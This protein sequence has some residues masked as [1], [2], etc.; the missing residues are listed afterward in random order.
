MKQ[1][2]KL[3]ALSILSISMVS[4]VSTLIIGVIPQLANEFP[5]LPLVWSE[6]LVT[7]ANLSALLTLLLNPRLSAYFGA[8]K[9]VIS[10]LLI[11]MITGALPFILH[12]FTLLMLSRILLGLG[13]GLFSPHALSLIARVYHGELRARLLGYQTGL[14]ALGNAV[15]LAL[16][17]SVILL[18]WRAVFLLYLLLGGVAWLV[19]KF[20]PHT[21]TKTTL[22]QLQPRLPRTKWWLTV[23]AF[24]T[25]VLIWGVQ[26]KLPSLFAQRG[27][28]DA[29]VVSWTLA[30]MNIGGLAAGLTFGAL[31]RHWHH[32]ILL[33]GYAG[34]ASAVLGLLLAPNAISAM[35]AAILFNFIYS[36]TGPYLIFRGHAG[37]APEQIDVMSRNL[38]I[39]TVIS[40]FFAPLMWNL[41]G[42][43]GPGSTTV[44]SLLWMSGTLLLLAGGLE[45]W[46][47]LSKLTHD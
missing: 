42:K 37:L 8:R 3:T 41:V 38:T 35:V 9:V 23:L 34:A 30:V 27:F 11:S 45:V 1:P 21:T 28:G 16:A 24:V 4:G 2:T 10:G 36:Y 14:T 20:V 29:G 31:Y 26:L 32:Y 39:A 19:T 40:A 17:G 13:I 18:S 5:N 22:R 44:N 46:F 12:D 15:F 43:V 47:K 25:Y 7:A 33:I 6:W